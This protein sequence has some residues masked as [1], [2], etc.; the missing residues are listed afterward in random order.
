MILHKTSIIFIYISP[1]SS[2]R[3]YPIYKFIITNNLNHTNISNI[4]LKEYFHF[5]LNIKG[6]GEIFDNKFN[7][8]VVKK[9]SK[10]PRIINVGELELIIG[11][12]TSSKN[13]LELGFSP[14][15]Y[16]IKAE[17]IEYK[18]VLTNYK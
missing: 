18:D 17:K 7:A 5:S 2:S 10:S 14:R 8:G 12:Q 1:I 9:P 13:Y 4:N 16:N 11:K 15:K 3:V 6:V